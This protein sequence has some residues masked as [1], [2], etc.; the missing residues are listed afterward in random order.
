MALELEVKVFEDNRQEWSA[1]HHGEFVV[2]QDRIVL[3]FFP[4]WEDGIKAGYA[5]FGADRAFLVK[6]VLLV[7][8]VYFVGMA[9]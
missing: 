2:I 8:R 6:E 5:S 7:D 3:G 1:S 9:A 4:T